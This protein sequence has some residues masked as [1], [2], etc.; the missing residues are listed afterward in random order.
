[1]VELLEEQKGGELKK[2]L[3]ENIK[4]MEEDW[5]KELIED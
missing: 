2:S 4:N 5:K 1:M 3:K